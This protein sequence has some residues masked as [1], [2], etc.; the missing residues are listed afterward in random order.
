ML[1]YSPKQ[2]IEW[3]CTASTAYIGNLLPLY[4]AYHETCGA[5]Y[6]QPY[7]R[8]NS[9]TPYDKWNIAQARPMSVSDVMSRSLQS[10][11]PTTHRSYSQLTFFNVFIK[12][13]IIKKALLFL[14]PSH[15]LSS[16]FCSLS[17]LV[18]TQIRGH[19]TGSSTPLPT[20]VRALHFYRERISALSSLVDSSRRTVLT[21]GRRSQ[22]LVYLFF[23]WGKLI[24]NLATAGFELKP[25]LIVAFEGYQ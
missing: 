19:I 16:P 14:P 3:L 24:Q 2:S 15:L 18:A 1:Y 9:Q 5:E 21:H 8:C 4:T 13:F 10:W 25:L 22:Q 20:T 7:G 11:V 12:L 6:Q 17:L 23:F